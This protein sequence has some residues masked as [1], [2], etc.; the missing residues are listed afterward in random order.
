MLTTA[1]RYQDLPISKSLLIL[2]CLPNETACHA[3]N[4]YIQHC[5]NTC[6]L[7]SIEIPL[8][9]HREQELLTLSITPKKDRRHISCFSEYFLMDERDN[10]HRQC[11]EENPR[12]IRNL[13]ARI[14][15]KRGSVVHRHSRWFAQRNISHATPDPQSHTY[16][17]SVLQLVRDSETA[18]RIIE[19]SLQIS[20]CQKGT[21]TL[22]IRCEEELES[23][24]LQFSLQKK[25]T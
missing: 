11:N 17:V 24:G 12:C 13:T 6:P 2:S 5:I 21:R 18:P 4:Q 1:H 22:A 19:I 3:L 7:S 23:Q 25:Y 8:L 10:P 9:S 16:D 15:H 20:Q 14:E